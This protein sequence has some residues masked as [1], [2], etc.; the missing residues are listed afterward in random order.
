MTGLESSSPGQPGISVVICTYS[1]E[2]WDLLLRT[3]SSLDNQQHPV[4]QVVVVVDHN[5]A[6]LERLRR[7]LPGVSAI[8]NQGPQG[9]S[10][11]RNTGAAAATGDIVASVDDD[12]ELAPDWSLRLAEDFMDPAVVGVGCAIAPDWEGGEPAWFPAEFYWVVGCTYRGV[13]GERREIR[14]PLGA[15][16]AIRRQVFEQVGGYRSEL[17]RFNKRPLG[18]EETELCVRVRQHNPQARFIQDPRARA[19]HYVPVERKTWRYFRSRCF[20]EG[21][22]KAMVSRSVGKSDGLESERSYVVRVLPRGIGRNL[23]AGI[24][25]DLPG[26]ARA[27]AIVAGLLW[28]SAGFVAGSVS[29]RSGE[30]GHREDLAP[31]NLLPLVKEQ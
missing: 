20:A 19:S 2:R 31:Q 24:R 1:E 16:M 9:L 10:G 22:S 28:T 18:C 8:S 7:H 30:A 21:L 5:D 15:A 17:G 27:G 6:L 11:G 29:R 26:F 3:L 12:A 23:L 25:G 13:P 4:E 14:N